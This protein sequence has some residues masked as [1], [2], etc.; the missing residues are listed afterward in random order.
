M[1]DRWNYRAVKSAAFQP[2]DQ[3]DTIWTLSLDRTM[4]CSNPE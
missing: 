1:G 2:I 3:N 4:M